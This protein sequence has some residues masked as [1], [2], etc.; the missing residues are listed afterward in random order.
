MRAHVTLGRSARRLAITATLVVTGIVF[1]AATP[2]NE[3]HPSGLELLPPLDLKAIATRGQI[4]ELLG[5]AW[6]DALTLAQ[7]E[8][9]AFGNP[10]ADR[11]TGRLVLTPTNAAAAARAQAWL[12]R[13]SVRTVPRAVRTTTR[14]YA[15]LEKIR[16]EAIGPGAADLPNGQLIWSTYMDEESNRVV[17]SIDHI[18][19]ALL[20]ALA[21]RYG[22]QAIVIRVEKNPG[23]GS[24]ARDNDLSAFWGAHASTF[25]SPISAAQTRSRSC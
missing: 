7:A 8:P 1:G 10:F 3:Q 17:I 11:T 12:P 15:Q 20:F 4:A 18:D 24:I 2:L 22:T 14:S 23:F 6:E 9:D 25:P 16:N 21:A 13:A 19:D 5:T